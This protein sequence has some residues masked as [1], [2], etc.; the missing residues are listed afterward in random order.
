MIH[1]LTCPMW[2]CDEPLEEDGLGWRC[3]KDGEIPAL[4]LEGNLGDD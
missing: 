3:P 4:L 2:G 1:V